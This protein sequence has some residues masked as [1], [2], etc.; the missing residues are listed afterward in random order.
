MERNKKY[1][2]KIIKKY[3]WGKITRG[4]PFFYMDFTYTSL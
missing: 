4:S 3:F 1:Q 2:N